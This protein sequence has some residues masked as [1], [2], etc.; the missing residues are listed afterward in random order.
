MAS[1][2]TQYS[3][4]IN[5]NFPVPGEDNDSQGFR[6]NFAKI[7][8]ALG[9]ASREISTIQ[10]GAVNL[11]DSNDFGENIVKRAALQM[12]S[13][14]VNDATND[15]LGDPIVTVDYTL[16][17]YQK[18][19]ING[20]DYTFTVANWPSSGLCGAVR[21]EIT[22]SS[23]S[24]VTV[25]FGSYGDLYVLSQNDLPVAYEQTVPIVWDLYSPDNGTTVFAYEVGVASAAVPVKLKS[26][27]TATLSTYTTATVNPPTNGTMVFV[28]DTTASIHAPA[29]FK[30][31]PADTTGTWYVMSGTPLVL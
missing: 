9:V 21:L 20:G 5:V 22:P 4:L 29:F 15:L 7:Q 14:V 25:N 16:G 18:F 12:P 28:S 6:S 8:S 19:A 11:N 23:I 13:L 3:N 17:S 1:T 30:K 31:L 10:A 27:F 24:R 2:I 26:Y